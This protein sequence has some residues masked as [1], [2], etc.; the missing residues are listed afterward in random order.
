MKLV[1]DTY[2]DQIKKE[3][4]AHRTI[5]EML[6]DEKMKDDSEEAL[7]MATLASYHRNQLI[8]ILLL[9]VLLRMMPSPS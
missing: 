3:E 7:V 2:E 5:A 4:I 1:T 9:S 6:E 8:L